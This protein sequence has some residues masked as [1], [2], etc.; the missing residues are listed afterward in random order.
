MFFNPTQYYLPQGLTPQFAGIPSGGSPFAPMGVPFFGQAGSFASQPYPYGGNSLPGAGHS[1]LQ[2]IVPMVG[3]LAQ[4]ISIH[5]VVTQQIAQL[6]HQVT[7][8]L[9]LGLQGSLAGQ[10]AFGSPFLGGGL[11]QSAGQTP[12]ALAPGGYA[13]FSP[14][15]QSWGAARPQ[16]VQ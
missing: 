13:G 1:P 10:P 9:A 5:S 16:T 6:L 8:Q 11:G 12:F 15:A 2:Q 3:Q 4:Q 7:H 14:Q